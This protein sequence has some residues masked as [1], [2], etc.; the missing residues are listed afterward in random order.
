M[1]ITAVNVLQ[2]L[3]S[4]RNL[5]RI[6]LI[7]QL[8]PRRQFVL[9]APDP[10]AETCWRDQSRGALP[11]QGTCYPNDRQVRDGRRTNETTR[12]PTRF[13]WP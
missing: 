6:L 10:P 11:E 7:V 8:A 3:Y 4:P 9:T 12:S 1:G 5:H 13:S 2:L